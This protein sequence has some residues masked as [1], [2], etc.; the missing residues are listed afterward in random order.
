MVR[1]LPGTFNSRLWGYDPL[2]ENKYKLSIRDVLQ[3]DQYG[4]YKGVYKIANHPVTTVWIM[5]DVISI[6]I[7]E[8]Y[9]SYKGMYIHR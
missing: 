5:G 8:K 7:K 6:L 4:S 1:E 2:L 3:L 9:I